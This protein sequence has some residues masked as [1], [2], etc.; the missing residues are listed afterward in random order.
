M[1]NYISERYSSEYPK[2][3]AVTHLP[4]SG[5][6]GDRVSGGRRP[7]NFGIFTN[8]IKKYIIRLLFFLPNNPRAVDS[9]CKLSALQTCKFCNRFVDFEHFR[10][11]NDPSFIL[12]VI[13]AAKELPTAVF[14]VGNIQYLFIAVQYVTTG[15]AHR[16]GC[17]CERENLIKQMKFHHLTIG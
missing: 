12:G 8:Y 5:R 7:R 10:Q 2:E 17:I 16:F 11:G 14:I 4:P 6:E 1:Q 13:S 15:E 9:L 3:F